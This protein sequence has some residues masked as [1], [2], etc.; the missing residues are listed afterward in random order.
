MTTRA[1]MAHSR[2]DLPAGLAMDGYAARRSPASGTRD[3]LEATALYVADGHQA[4]VLVSLDL[5]AVGTELVQLLRAR[6]RHELGV[7]NVLVA[8][9]HT[10]AGPSGV[11]STAED[12]TVTDAVTDAVRSCVVRA[13][14]AAAP[15]R[16]RIGTGRLPAGV[17]TNRNDPQAPIDRRLTTIRLSGADG[18]PVGLLWHTGVHPTVLGPD[19]LQYSADLPGEVRRRLRRDDEPVIFLNGPAGDVSSRF[20]R[21]GRDGA[22]LERLG[23]L[24]HDAL[25][26]A[27]RPIELAPVVMAERV[28]ALQPAN[29]E[30]RNDEQLRR[31][32]VQ[33]LESPELDAGERRR[34][35]SLLE[36]LAR[37]SRQPPTDNTVEARMQVLRLGDLTLAAVPGE[38]V[39]ALGRLSPGPE[40][41]TVLLVGYANGYVG[42]L[43]T[44]TDGP[45][46]ETLASRVDLGT[47][48]R[49]L[50]IADELVRETFGG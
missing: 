14:D 27:Q 48:V 21:R 46:Y 31:H 42:Y 24:L 5:V 20:V 44:P 39:S 49:L 26:R 41:V 33:L 3:P 45:T 17:A 30:V 40:G 22:E 12:E 43:T 2:M 19:N 25:P 16:A 10:H 1:G 18:S 37:R 34:L 29:H 23:R 11:R 28:V 13:A 6:L 32:T 47:G 15:V 9:T 35:E 50:G 38:A 36:G 7:S 4:A 8:A